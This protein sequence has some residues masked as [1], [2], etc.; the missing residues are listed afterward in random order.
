MPQKMSILFTPKKIGQ[1][2][3]KNRFVHS[4]T[5]ESMA[6]RS[7]EVT[8]D[9][10]KRYCKLARGEVGLI[11]PGFMYVHRYGKAQRY[12]TGIYNDG[13]VP[14]LRQL[15]DAIHGEGSKVFFQLAHSGSQTTKG[16]L[17]KKPMGTSSTRRDP[18]Y[19][20]RPIKMTDEDIE[21]IIDS[22]GEAA[23][24]AAEAGADGV[25]LHAAHGY[26]MSQFLS[27]FLNDRNDAWGG[28]DEKRFRLLR[29]IFLK[30]RHALPDSM[31]LIVKINA[32]DCVPENGVIP[33]LAR[34]YCGWLAE[35]GVDGVEVSCGL[36][37]YSYMSIIRG[38]VP[39]E[40]LKRFPLWKRFI[41]WFVLKGKKGEFGFEE[42]YNV[43]DAKVIRPAIGNVPLIVVGGMRSKAYM[44]Q[45]LS[46]GSADFVSICRPF[47][48][49]PTLVKRFRE[50]KTEVASCVSCNQCF[51][52]IRNNQPVRCYNKTASILNSEI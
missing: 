4:A 7:G 26:L 48:R 5:N 1:V 6:S 29:E 51:A 9:L 33:D 32:N 17:G 37:V 46:D 23:R 21:L 18:V 42:G 24:R 25:Q 20:F 39:M 41:G 13:M 49:E 12:Q 11:I 38:D 44:E 36:G 50:G 34:K 15:V 22:F 52:A 40:L 31:P 10:V 16:T 45:I 3:I 47:I 27:P 43:R 30:V 14:G 19:L 35:L 28:T 8:D 2:E